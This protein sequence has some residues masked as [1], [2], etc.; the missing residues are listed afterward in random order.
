VTS[1]RALSRVDLLL[2]LVTLIWGSNF[3]II[4]SAFRE[5]EP[6]AFNALRLALASTTFLTI[7]RIV[8]RRHPGPGAPGWWRF[9]R[10]DAVL[11]RGDWVSLAIIGAIG[12]FCYQ[13][14]WVAGLT[15]TTVANSSLILGLT[16]AAVA[17]ASAAIG[18]EHLRRH[19]WIGLAL[20]LAGLYLVAGRG[21]QVS[22]SALVGDGLTILAVICWTIYTLMGQRLMERHSPL[23]VTGLSMA[24]GVVPYLLVALPALVRTPWASVSLTTWLSLVFSAMLALCL[25]YLIWYVS[26][27]LIG[28]A[29]TSVYSN[30][31]PIVAMLVAFVWLGEPIGWYKIAG[32]AAVL[33]GV[34]I[35][36][37]ERLP[38]LLPAEE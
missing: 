24:L 34:A 20:S 8:Q 26:V 37:L 15:R 19:H 14:C 36:R 6:I 30:V 4:K 21:A 1:S 12:H 10:T 5:L 13:L 28:S 11:T 16:P 32:A 18:D 38:F 31:T 29:R 17:V 25:S 22:R 2:L 23:G 7:M 3:T 33:G 9:L 35:T 27:R